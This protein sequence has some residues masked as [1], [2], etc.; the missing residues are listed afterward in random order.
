MSNADEIAKGLSPFN[1]ASAQLQ[2]GKLLLQ[3]LNASLRRKDTFAL[4]STLSG[5]TYV[6]YLRLA[7]SLGYRIVLHFLWLPSAE[8]SYFRVK[9]RVAEGGHDVP[10]EDIRRRYKRILKNLLDF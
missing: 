5:K 4:E 9:Q 3:N 7:C 10:S 2:A 1:P 6:K 8:E